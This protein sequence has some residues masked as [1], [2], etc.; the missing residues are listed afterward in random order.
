MINN[1]QYNIEHHI[2][3]LEYNLKQLPVYQLY[4]QK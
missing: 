1:I 2:A 3:D 4:F